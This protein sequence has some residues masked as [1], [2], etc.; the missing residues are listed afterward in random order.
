MNYYRE[1]QPIT[2][3]DFL[4][5]LGSGNEEAITRAIMD[6]VDAIDDP[7]WLLAKL[8]HVLQNRSELWI[9]GTTIVALTE[10]A[11]FNPEIDPDEVY[12]LIEPYQNKESFQDWASS[13]LDDLQ[14]LMRH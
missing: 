2:K 1:R 7:V 5:E 8:K 10:L 11:L 12:L 13:A 14:N 9:I 4:R 3:D 6:A